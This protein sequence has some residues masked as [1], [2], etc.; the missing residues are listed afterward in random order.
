[1]TELKKDLFPRYSSKHPLKGV[2]S[3]ENRHLPMAIFEITE[4]KLMILVSSGLVTF[5][6][7]P[8]FFLF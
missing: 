7:S 5:Y 2:G 8:L 6:L 4:L 3:I 1:M